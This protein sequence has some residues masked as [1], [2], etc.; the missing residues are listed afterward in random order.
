MGKT[1]SS[2]LLLSCPDFF[3]ES[4]NS[5]AKSISK[6]KFSQ[7]NVIKFEWPLM[8]K[9]TLEFDIEL[10]SK[11]MIEFKHKLDPKNLE[12]PNTRSPMS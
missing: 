9:L 12:T 2:T 7:F 8:M 4:D 10:G 3:I 11:F 6:Y 1:N 5:G